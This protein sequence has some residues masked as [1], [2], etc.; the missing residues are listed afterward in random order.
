MSGRAATAAARTAAGSRLCDGHD[1]ELLAFIR[2]SRTLGLHLEDI[3]EVIAIR[4]GGTAP[5]SAVRALLDARIAEVD[6]AVAE[7]LAPAAILGRDAS[8]GSGLSGGQGRLGVR[9]H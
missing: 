8:E 4:Q 5:C 3:R 1:V 2:R 9:H 6:Y 7:L